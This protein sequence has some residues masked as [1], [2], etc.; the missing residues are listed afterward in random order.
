MKWR[1]NH[2]HLGAT[3]PRD[4]S[5]SLGRCG[6]PF[7]GRSCGRSYEI[8]HLVGNS[9]GL[10]RLAASDF[11]TDLMVLGYY[12]QSRITGYTVTE[13]RTN[14]NANSGIDHAPNKCPRLA[15]CSRPIGGLR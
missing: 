5:P 12:V 7:R 2:L 15:G 1:I 9:S 3:A 14:N 11:S 13:L 8:L 10:T 4:A 6:Q